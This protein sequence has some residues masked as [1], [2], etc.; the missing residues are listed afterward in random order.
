MGPE[1]GISSSTRASSEV[2]ACSCGKKRKIIPR[3]G[4]DRTACQ[5]VTPT[6]TPTH[7]SGDGNLH[8]PAAGGHQDVLGA[9]P[10][11]AAVGGSDLGGVGGRGAGGWWW[12]AAGARCHRAKSSGSGS[13]GSTQEQQQQPGAAAARSSSSSGGGS[14][15]PQCVGSESLPAPLQAGMWWG[16]GG[17]C[18]RQLTID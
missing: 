14:P 11:Y 15:P 3:A 5:L 4:R 13:S 9:Q 17:M 16:E 6:S 18:D 1:V 10:T 8:R 7:R 12:C 2:M